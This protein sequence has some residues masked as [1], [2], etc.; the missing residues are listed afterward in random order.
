MEMRCS[1]SETESYKFEIREDEIPRGF[2]PENE[3]R[4]GRRPY[5]IDGWQ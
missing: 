5:V 1:V 3:F 4:G 2:R